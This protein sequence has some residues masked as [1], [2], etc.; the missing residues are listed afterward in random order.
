[1]ALGRLLP[2]NNAHDATLPRSAGHRLSWGCPFLPGVKASLLP[3]SCFQRKFT[4][5]PLGTTLGV[6]LAVSQKGK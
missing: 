6:G 1:M 2:C 4:E 3:S 5:A